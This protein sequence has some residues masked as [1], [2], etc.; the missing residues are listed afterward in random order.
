MHGRISSPFPFLDQSRNWLKQAVSIECVC[1]SVLVRSQPVTRLEMMRGSTSICSIL[2]SSS[3]GKAKYLI[4]LRDSLW[5]RK[6]KPR[7]TPEYICIHTDK[8]TRLQTQTNQVTSENTVSIL[9]RPS[10]LT[11]NHGSNSK[12]N[13]QIPLEESF[14]AVPT[15]GAHPLLHAAGSPLH[16]PV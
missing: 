12:Q 13:E 16:G 1:C 4:S 14:G 2:I 9:R 3:P 7:I 11:Q 8:H 15:D 10:S 5:G 6:V